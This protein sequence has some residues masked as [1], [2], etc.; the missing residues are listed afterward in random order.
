VIEL[1]PFGLDRSVGSGGMGQVWSGIHRR[2]KYPVAIK[3][4]T[5]KG[6]RNQRYLDA[7]RSEVRSA[8]A[9]DHP[10]I[11]RVFD[12][13]E[14]D[15]KT[16]AAT[17]GAIPAGSPWLAMEF[18]EGGTLSASC[19][20]LPWT[21]VES[22]IHALLDALGH[23]HARG[24]IHRDLKPS[25]VLVA[26][27]EDRLPL[28]K[29]TDFGLAQAIESRELEGANPFG[30]GTPAYMAPEQFDGRWRDYGPW[31]D[32]YAA[33]C[34]FFA[35]IR[36]VPPFGLSP[37]VAETRKLHLEKPPPPLDPPYSVPDGFE[38]WLSRLLDKDPAT[39]FRRAA[40]AMHA[41][42][43]LG[44][45]TEPRTRERSP[46]KPSGEGAQ[47]DTIPLVRQE[48]V[49]THLTLAAPGG[50]APPL[51]EDWRPLE[52]D[53]AA[54]EAPLT[55]LGLFGLRT[56][57]F[58]GRVTERTALWQALH[59]TVSTGQVHVVVLGGPEGSGKSRLAEWL[60]QRAHEVG[61]AQTM[62]ATHGPVGAHGSGLGAML[63]AS[64]RCQGLD[65]A[66]VLRRVESIYRAHDILQPDEWAAL[67]ELICPAEPGMAGG[68]RFA[69]PTERYV[70][71]RRLLQVMAAER[72]VVLVLD[73]AQFGLDALRFAAYL[74]EYRAKSLPVL[75]VITAT[76]E[77]LAERIDEGTVV[78]ELLGHERGRRIDVANLPPEE[79]G[80]LVRA[81][82]DLE[83]AL[84]IKVEDRTA[85]NPLFAVQLVGDWAH[86]SAVMPYPEGFRLRYEEEL[87]TDARAMWAQRIERLVAD[88]DET[89][90]QSL[91]LAAMLG[92][93][94]D[95]TE[96]GAAC[97]RAG[98]LLAQATP[99]PDAPVLAPGSSLQDTETVD[100]HHL[101]PSLPLV[102]LLLDQRLV[103][104]GPAGPSQGWSFTHRALRAALVQRAVA[105]KRAVRWHRAC[106][107]VLAASF[108]VSVDPGV[109]AERIGR[110]W[111]GA[112]DETRALEPL[113]IA[114]EHRVAQGHYAV[115]EELLDLRDSAFENT[116]VP[117]SDP[118]W[119]AGWL[120]RYETAT[121]QGRYADAA[122]WLEQ[123]EGAATLFGWSRIRNRV[124]CL[125]GRQHRIHGQHHQA[126]VVL[127]EVEQDA[128]RRSDRAQQ[129]EAQLEMSRT[130][131]GVAQ[132][133]DA[134]QWV[135]KALA[136]YEALDDSHG[137]AEA[138]QVMAE[139]LREAGQYPEATILLR[140]AEVL[141]TELGH[142]F[143][144]AGTLNGQGELA[145]A[146][147]DL[148]LAVT[149]YR[150]ARGLLKAIGSRSWVVPEYNAGLVHL[151]RGDHRKARPMIETAL[152]VFQEQGN[153]SALAHAHLALAACSALDEQW[154][155][156]DD[157]LRE[158]VD[159]LVSID[160]SDEDTARLAMRAAAAA[161][162]H[163]QRERASSAYKLALRMW[164]AL[165]REKEQT[166][167]TKAIV[168]LAA[169]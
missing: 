83:P 161:E 117:N 42:R 120:L 102:H 155:L 9:L 135:E 154:L 164:S 25:N 94:V 36:G 22:V 3:F 88:R 10:H 91:E 134:Q 99:A 95:P 97:Q 162:K 146:Q 70:T 62:R 158:A 123:I 138:W 23:A 92:M 38:W 109:L 64:L 101:A 27:A 32:L 145:R 34:L 15:T 111:L 48:P 2:L 46:D 90:A 72:S 119:G 125:V 54:P 65:R 124:R 98:E 13:G 150:R 41:F 17:G 126:L 105:G 133:S 165:D 21:A 6:F 61:A 89:E 87:P 81:L 43:Q 115:A 49:E 159:T 14:V 93:R 33:G 108:E 149:L 169:A 86:R 67:T 71:I 8:A 52:R 57:P 166:E 167:V 106:A 58:V 59:D 142:R 47:A 45:L 144:V 19:G 110:H 18:V 7:F 24:V 160:Y 44:P 143:M 39:R 76:D 85:G 140:K 121:R 80:E 112:G 60:S 53:G 163:D 114:A 130:L 139:A 137:R 118:R 26:G 50:R 84:A 69:S 55:G 103:V 1:G 68:V 122:Q 148:D 157:H 16:E 51:P 28:V 151:T 153:Q 136:S 116:D 78:A 152:A 31:T 79:R 131:L 73:D 104:S 40:D 107:E 128:E 127:A 56:I 75:I 4:L 129:A 37:D 147:G 141:F 132:V 12:H 156:W 30:G 113:Y 82:L 29:L 63:R 168:R 20:R 100:R 77:L 35:L 74:L 96:W 11:V 5:E 66:A